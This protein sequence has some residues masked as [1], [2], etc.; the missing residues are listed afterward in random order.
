MLIA[1]KKPLIVLATQKSL[2]FIYIIN[3]FFVG[4]KLIGYLI[5]G[6][7]HFTLIPIKVPDPLA[8]INKKRWASLH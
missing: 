1:N 3:S 2:F 5:E 4:V 8:R 6:I 7:E